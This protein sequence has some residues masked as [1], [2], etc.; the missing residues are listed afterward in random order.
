ML[1]GEMASLT[2]LT[3]KP[4]R[5]I[6]IA[7]DFSKKD[8]HLIAYALAQGNKE[9][10]YTLIH[11]VESASAKY[12]GEDTDDDE[13]RQD[14]ER[15]NIYTQ[16]LIDYGYKATGV[17]GYRSRIKEI[18]R[19]VNESE[20]DLLVMGSHKHSG[21]RDYIFG[22]TIDAVRHVVEVPVLIV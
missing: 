14:I 20:A 8:E 17:V 2:D 21:I 6:A 12:L 4:I 16:H 5:N 13:T 22:E 19:I 9:V 10:H 1:H 11:I 18:V 3:V 7:L 15:L